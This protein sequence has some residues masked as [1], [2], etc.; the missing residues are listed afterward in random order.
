MCPAQ[1]GSLDPTPVGKHGAVSKLV[2]SRAGMR[3]P[4]EE[5]VPAHR[6]L[7]NPTAGRGTPFGTIL[8]T[9]PEEVD[10]MRRSLAIA[11]WLTRADTEL[12]LDICAALLAERSAIGG[13][14]DELGPP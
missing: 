5:A 13:I 6:L 2:A 7:N 14:F 4:G 8:G 11:G 12:L 3:T 1:L 10:G 9:A